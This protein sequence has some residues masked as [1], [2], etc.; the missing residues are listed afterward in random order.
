M[1]WEEKQNPSPSQLC[2]S[3]LFK[4]QNSNLSFQKIPA[5]CSPVQFLPCHRLAYTLGW[6]RAAAPCLQPCRVAEQG[7]VQL[8]EGRTSV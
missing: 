8:L 2:I 3:V 7:E 1:Y 4:L 6:S 5:L